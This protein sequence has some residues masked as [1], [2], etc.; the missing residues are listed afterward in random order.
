MR[1][2]ESTKAFAEHGYVLM[3]DV[4]ALHLLEE[5]KRHLRQLFKAG[6]HKTTEAAI[7]EM[8]SSSHE[9]V[10]NASITV[11]ST[12]A[13]Y[14]LIH[15]LGLES[16]AEEFLGEGYFHVTPLHVSMQMPR[17]KKYDYA[18]HIESDFYPW[19]PEILNLWF[20]ILASTQK[21]LT[22]TIEVIPGSHL[23]TKRAHDIT[24]P[25]GYVQII[26]RLDP[27]EEEWG[28]QIEA[29]PGDLLIFHKRMVHRTCPNLC[30]VPRATGIVRV[31]DQGKLEKTRPLY[32]AMSYVE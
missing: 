3:R 11:G 21:D 12:L 4:I 9:A 30:N 1:V 28:L 27:G 14:R 6:D 15:S 2:N 32:K 23:K 5:V 31:I 7:M 17:D 10:Y 20:P 8:E 24:H 26:S 29:N 19:A 18:W 25:G 22:G 13:A 16:W